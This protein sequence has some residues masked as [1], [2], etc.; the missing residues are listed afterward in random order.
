MTLEHWN[1]KHQEYL[2]RPDIIV[3]MDKDRIVGARPFMF[4]E[5]R[6]GNKKVNAA[7]HTDT[8]VDPE[9]QGKG[10][11]NRMG[12]F[13]IRY[14]K[15]SGYA[16]SYGFPNRLSRAGFQKQGWRIVGPTESM[17]RLIKPRNVM[18]HKLKSSFLGD[19]TGLLYGA[20]FR[21]KTRDTTGLSRSFQVSVFDRFNEGLNE[22]DILRDERAIDLVRSESFLRWRFDD[23]PLFKYK[24]VAI[25][26]QGKLKGY[27]VIR[28]VTEDSE[29]TRGL[30]IDYLVKNYDAD[31]FQFLLNV[32]LNE[33]EKEGC[34]IVYVWMVSESN[35]LRA[36]FKRSGFKS[37]LKISY[38]K[39]LSYDYIDAISIG[40]SAAGSVDIYDKENW[41]VSYA[42]SDTR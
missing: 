3:A 35:P 4:V 28:T 20:I 11:F 15:D 16:L 41:R 21:I 40:E 27:A 31:C 23:N 1:W 37:S 33:F 30:I 9:Y 2:G 14:L 6:L 7:Q 24:Y 25:T 13:S 18:T 32:C 22:V 29:L 10:I 5:L 39:L 12:Q 34:D 38:N 8:M 19:V 36:L 17:Y 26:K 42:F